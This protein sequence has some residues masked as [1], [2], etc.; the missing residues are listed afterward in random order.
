MTRHGSRLPLL[1]LT[2]FSLWITSRLVP[3]D[4]GPPA[5]FVYVS[6]HWQ[7]AL[8]GA[9]SKQGVHQFFDDNGVGC[10]NVLTARECQLLFKSR[11]QEVDGATLVVSGV[12]NR[13]FSGWM[14]AS[15]RMAL[16]IPLHPDRMEVTDWQA[17]PGIGP[18]TASA[19]EN[20]RQKNGDFEQVE[21]LLRVKGVGEKRLLR[22]VRFF[23]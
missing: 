6:P 5:F 7:V 21:A 20:N 19:I 12:D 9:W 1:L 8:S 16:Q 23:E 15:Q 4:G 17:L 10:V 3:R 22:I 13:E 14:P 2:L 11:Y 18:S